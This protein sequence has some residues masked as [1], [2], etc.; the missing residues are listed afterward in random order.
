MSMPWL[1]ARGGVAEKVKEK[2]NVRLQKAKFMRI[3]GKKKLSGSKAYIC[4]VTLEKQVGDSSL[5]DNS[6]RIKPTRG[7]N[8]KW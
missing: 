4:L 2:F 6:L 8:S 5:G 3:S 7:Q 1:P